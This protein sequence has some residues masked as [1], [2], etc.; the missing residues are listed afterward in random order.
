M[1]L[2]SYFC[3]RL[4]HARR[5]VTC[6]RGRFGPLPAAFDGRPIGRL[7]INLNLEMEMVWKRLCQGGKHWQH[8]SQF[9]GQTVLANGSEVSWPHCHGISTDFGFG[10]PTV[11]RPLL[12]VGC[13]RLCWPI[14][15]QIMSSHYQWVASVCTRHHHLITGLSAE[16]SGE[17]SV[18]CGTSITLS[19]SYGDCF[20]S[21]TYYLSFGIYA[22]NLLDILHLLLKEGSVLDVL[23]NV[24][25]IIC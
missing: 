5:G 16:A 4:A 7:G 10:G 14:A 15:I 8:S 24:F 6:V 13:I 2:P 25:W 17:T 9:R 11:H 3:V 18:D 1:S 20:S 12:W 23:P 19:S 21:E 22:S